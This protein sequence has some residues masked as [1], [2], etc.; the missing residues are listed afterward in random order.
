MEQRR[1]GL[2]INANCER[3]K[4]N[5]A[6][7]GVEVESWDKLVQHAMQRL[8]ELER[9]LAECQLHLTSSENEIETMKAVEKIHL[10]DL[11]IARE[12]TDQIA[13]RIDEVRLFVDDVN[14]AAA[15]LLAED[16]KLDEHARGQIEHVNKRYSTLKRAIRIRQAAV[17]N[18]ASD[19]GPTSEH[20]LNQ[21]VTLPWQRAISKSN[22]LPYYIE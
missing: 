5:W 10:E 3:L 11:K 13:R 9:N 14:D 18:A 21:S 12:E 8:Q 19:F 7:L 17:R 6:E 4:K 2:E 22:L 1:R 16:L 20:F 15:R